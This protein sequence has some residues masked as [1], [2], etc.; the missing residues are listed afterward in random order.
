MVRV[1]DVGKMRKIRDQLNKENKIKF[2]EAVRQ[3]EWDNK[4]R[5]SLY[6]DKEKSAFYTKPVHMI[7]DFASRKTK[8]S[9]LDT[10]DAEI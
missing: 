6:F 2:N 3:L 4:S 7:R 9:F 1:A 10:C 8:H 5:L